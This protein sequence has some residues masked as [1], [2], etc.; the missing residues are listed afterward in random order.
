M[1]AGPVWQANYVD[2]SDDRAVR[3]GAECVI[4]G[5][6]YVTEPEPLAAHVAGGTEPDPETA[7]HIE[8]QKFRLF[9]EFDEAFRGITINCFRCGRAACPDCWDSDKQM[10]GS[11]VAERGLVRSPYWGGPVEGPLA[12]G[13]LRRAEAGRYAEVGRPTWLKELLRAQSEPDVPRGAEMAAHGPLPA[14]AMPG[15]GMAPQVG[16]G[17]AGMPAA[18]PAGFPAAFPGAPSLPPDPPGFE[19]PPTSKMPAGARPPGAKADASRTLGDLAGPEGNATSG[20]LECP[21]CG[22]ANYDFVTQCSECGLQLIQV[23]SAC[24][25]LNPGHAEQCQYCGA[26]LERPRG[27]S[28]VIGPIVSLEPGEARRRMKGRL[29]ASP[30]VPVGPQ[31]RNPGVWQRRSAIPSGPA[32]NQGRNRG[33]HSRALAGG[34]DVTFAQAGSA[35]HP[36]HAAASVPLQASLGG[37]H[38]YDP[39]QGL[40]PIIA[41][42]AVAPRPARLAN[43]I[44]GLGLAVEKLLTAAVLLAVVAALAAVVAAEASPQLNHTLLLLVHIDIHQR[45]DVIIQWLRKLLQGHQ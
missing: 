1:V 4:C 45:V 5:A 19:P 30:S 9:G 22:A 29:P 16:G 37:P 40:Q 6:R 33:G 21:R 34:A 43:L 26:A 13:F 8:D 36:Y 24:E 25:K 15:G 28:G 27:W 35:N 39:G 31:K 38:P 11:C 14:L 23:C 44:Y 12:D 18:F 7:R 32:K 17:P 42:Q 20:M 10:C 3:F 41:T 2:L